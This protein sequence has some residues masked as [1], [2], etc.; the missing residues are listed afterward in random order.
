[1]QNEKKQTVS[2]KQVETAVYVRAKVNDET[3]K[4]K[5]SAVFDQPIFIERNNR[6][7]DEVAF[8]T[9]SMTEVLIDQ[10]LES[11]A[12]DIEVLHTIRTL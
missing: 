8:I 11:L 12:E 3:V 2:H 7:D 10:K 6:P 9:S 4:A 5:I 1:M